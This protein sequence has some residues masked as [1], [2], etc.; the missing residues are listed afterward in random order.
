MGGQDAE[1]T[2]Y[3]FED[4]IPVS[5][6]GEEPILGYAFGEPVLLIPYGD[7]LA[8]VSANCTHYGGPLA[9][10]AVHDGKVYCP[11]HHAAFDLETG[12][13]E[14]PGLDP[15][16]CFE[17]SYSEGKM[18]VTGRK[19]FPDAGEP[20]NAPA[21]VVII[22]AGAAGSAC[23]EEL[24]RQGY[25][26]GVRLIGSEAS[27][28]VDRPNLSKDFLAGE[29]PAEWLA[30]RDDEWFEE[31]GVEWIAG[32]VV[33]L[34]IDSKELA[35]GTGRSIHYDAL[36]I[37]TGAA[38]RTLPVDGADLPHV[39]TLREIGDAKALSMAAENGSKAVVI[40]A[41]F[42]GLEA[43]ASLRKRDVEVH[44]VAPD[45]V[46]LAKIMGE[47][48]GKAVQAEHEGMGTTFH[49]ES[50][51]DSITESSVKLSD[52]TELEADIVVVGIGV[53]PRTE[54]AEAAGL[55]VDNGILVNDALRASPRI[56]AVGDVARFPSGND[57]ERIEHW[58]VARR[59]G[60]HAARDICGRAESYKD[61]PYFWSA[62]G[63]FVLQ[64]V[65]HAKSTED[66]RVSGSL[67]DKDA[68]ISYWES[69]KVTAVATIGRDV[70]SLE[71]EHMLAKGDHEALA[72]LVAD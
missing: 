35:L 36:V 51:V 30:V 11:W 28:A 29:A 23:A 63:E 46:P 40:G 45:A 57:T 42:I 66:V 4:G 37:A 1:L 47:E 18:K 9:D 52:G 41:S 32:E 38:A 48:V 67:A 25:N 17:V 59:Q 20:N 54:L 70:V 49:L 62:H 24:R 8:A 2:G 34:D 27:F 21:N 53:V 65:G 33:T 6:L 19:E 5:D 26:G 50:N 44:I 22:G 61:V 39:H 64:Y 15:V 43:A 58:V 3:D 7:R 10:G 55:S 69:G 60:Q 16:S 12:A 14:A 13:A 31:H 56:W 72:K 71:A 68:T